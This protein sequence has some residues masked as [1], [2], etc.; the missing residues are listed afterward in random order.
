MTLLCAIPTSGR[1]WAGKVVEIVESIPE[2]NEIIIGAQNNAEVEYISNGKTTVFRRPP[3]GV[4]GNR[5]FFCQYAIANEYDFLLQIDD[6]VRCPVEVVEHLISVATKYPWMGAMSS[7]S[8]WSQ[9][10]NHKIE[11]NMDFR[12]EAHC[13]QLHLLNIEATKEAISSYKEPPYDDLRASVDDVYYGLKMWSLG[14][15][16][17]KTNIKD[18]KGVY[19][20]IQGAVKTEDKGGIISTDRDKELFRAAKLFN[21]TFVLG[22]DSARDLVYFFKLYFDVKKGI[23][24]QRQRFKYRTM[25]R[26]FRDRWGE[27]GYEDSRGETRWL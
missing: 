9:F 2:I 26:N 3:D 25:Q 20:A 6:D 18:R 5:N 10:Y 7:D 21:K 1:S 11:T 4:S 8:N 16:C 12:T 15:M 27:I 23:Y 24:R 13:G 22:D 17:A 19:S 14:Y